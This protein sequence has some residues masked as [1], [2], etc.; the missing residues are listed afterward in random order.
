M[1]F[2]TKRLREERAEVV[3][4]L[5]ELASVASN[6]NRPMTAEERSQFDAIEQ[7]ERSLKDK[8]DTAERIERS[9]SL[10]SELSE[11]KPTA[12]AQ[13]VAT[14]K[15]ASD[16]TDAFRG[17]ALAGNKHNRDDYRNAAKRI[18]LDIDSRELYIPLQRGTN[19]Q[20]TSDALGGYT[21]PELMASSLETA[22]LQYSAIRNYANVVRTSGGQSMEFPTSNDTSNKAVIVNENTE[23]TVADTAFGNVSV[24]TFKFTSKLVK[25]SWELLADSQFNL[26][27][28]IGRALGERIGRGTN[29]YFTSGSG[30]SQPKGYLADSTEVAVCGT[31]LE[32]QDFIN[33][34]HGL[35][36]AYRANAVW[37][38]HDSVLAALKSVVDGDGR[39]IW[40]P[41][42]VAGS[43]DT[44]FGRPIVV[45]QSADQLLN[46]KKPLVFGDFSK[47]VIRDAGLDG[48]GSGVVLRRL[49]E[50]YAE[51]GMS[52]FLAVSR[53]GSALLDAGTHPVVHAHSATGS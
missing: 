50:R 44:I 20:S 13:P 28:Y 17:W 49:D 26:A 43:P 40:Q 24:P 3:K 8:I 5:Q 42:L 33:V 7:Q 41:S 2:E 21:I 31:T 39:L 15:R 38:L 51:F 52:A 23:I 53:H 30:S 34:Y 1:S 32:Y 48:F 36:P 14:Q 10:Y 46:N 37:V 4:Q 16:T 27:E 45:N 47:F 6:N 25:I 19:P 11:S 9:Q 22:L 29:D 18:G 12:V 35:D